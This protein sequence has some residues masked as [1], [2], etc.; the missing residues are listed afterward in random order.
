[1]AA[2]GTSHSPYHEVSL[3]D[4]NGEIHLQRVA[5]HP[6][7]GRSSSLDSLCLHEDGNFRL[8]VEPPSDP[9]S[10]NHPDTG[11][12]VETATLASINRHPGGFE[13]TK[14]KATA[15]RKRKL[16]RQPSTPVQSTR[17]A[18]YLKDG[19]LWEILC[20]IFSL[21]SIV[22]VIIL[23]SRL[24][25]TRLSNWTFPLQPSTLISILVTAAQSSMMLAVSAVISQLKWQYM[26]LPKARP[27]TDLEV[28]ES[29]SRGPLGSLSL[30]FYRRK[31][32]SG[33]LSTLIYTASLV[34]IAAL[35][36][37]PFAQQIVSIQVNSLEPVKGVNS[38]IAASD[39]YDNNN[40]S[41]G[42]SMF[43][44]GEGGITIARTSGADDALDVEPDMQGAFYTGIYHLDESYINFGCPS[45]NCS[46]GTFTFLG[47]CS[48]CQDVSAT[49]KI[50]R[51]PE[52]TGGTSFQT[53][54][55]WYL[56]M[57][58]YGTVV[59]RANSSLFGSTLDTLSARLVSLVVLQ[60]GSVVTGQFYTL[61]E[62]DIS[63]CAKQYSNFTVVR[64][65]SGPAFCALTNQPYMSI[66]EWS[67]PGSLS[68]PGTAVVVCKRSGFWWSCQRP[69]YRI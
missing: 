5:T 9:G 26:R 52:A 38:T 35:A 8:L 43:L 33:I 68:D 49:T 54:G 22:A 1:M 16:L 44:S 63:W 55:G 14:Q 23:A 45:G 39:Y 20:I 19:W 30:F 67:D 25:D 29:A 58:Y 65:L 60:A 24:Q 37:A 31:L 62:C 32:P 12:F 46:W 61:T 66:D 28:L 4:D 18:R 48:T 41:T 34:T 50:D 10:N 27:L 2:S 11:S 13:S 59:A 21:A 17:K 47:L 53:P 3:S 36:M 7:R 69:N 6:L 15:S 40:T 42:L 64:I 56:Y 57:E 51:S